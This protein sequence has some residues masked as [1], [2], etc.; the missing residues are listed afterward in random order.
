MPPARRLSGLTLMQPPQNP[1]EPAIP[2][3]TRLRKPMD[4]GRGLLGPDPP[5]HGV[6][7]RDE[8]AR[9]LPED[10]LVR[11]LARPSL[12]APLLTAADISSPA[13]AG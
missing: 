10:L 3:T 5:A 9:T 4:A 12:L 8:L 13:P 7:Q 2:S 1:P 11:A 6:R